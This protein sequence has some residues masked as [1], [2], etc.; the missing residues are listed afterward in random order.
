MKVSTKFLILLICMMV[1]AALT[2]K[3]Y[4]IPEVDRF[5]ELSVQHEM[6]RD[7]LAFEHIISV[8]V[9]AAGNDHGFVREALSAISTNPEI[10]IELR[11]G[12]LIDAQFGEVA[13]HGPRGEDERWVLEN[14]T[15]FFHQAE[16]HFEYIYPLKAQAVCANCHVTPAGEPVPEDAVLGLAV[17]RVPTETLQESSLRFFVMDVFWNNLLMVCLG[18]GL[19]LFSLFRWVFGPLD[20]VAG[21]LNRVL[22]NL[23]EEGL[24]QLE[25]DEWRQLEHGMDHLAGQLN[26]HGQEPKERQV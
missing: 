23:D 5:L 3:A 18:L 2:I 8:V 19:L 14:A 13:Q 9:S 22:S 20:R 21:K 4:F 17:K 10:P 7:M 24:S 26:A 25:G 6:Q 16:A 15:P 11:R 12:P 1:V